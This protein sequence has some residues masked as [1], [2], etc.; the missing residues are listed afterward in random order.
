MHSRYRLLLLTA[1]MFGER[2]NG[3]KMNNF[4]KGMGVATVTPF[5]DDG[6]V[7][8]PALQ[9]LVEHLVNGGVDYLVV[10]GTTAETPTLTKEERV[11]ILDFIKEINKGR[12]T[13]VLGMGGN[14]TAQ[15]VNEVESADLNGVDA[16]LS[17]SPSYNK[18]T[19][20]GIYQHYMAL[21]KASPLPVILYNVPGRTASNITADTTLRLAEDAG[22]II[23]IK[24][25]SNDLGQITRIIKNRPSG[26]LV[27]SGDD[28]LTLPI[29]SLGGDGVISVV[30]NAFPKRFSQLV[31]DAMSGD[32]KAARSKHYELIDVIE[33]LFTEG[34]PGGVKA[35]L[36]I[37]GITGDRLRLPLVGISEDLYTRSFAE[38]QSLSKK[39]HPVSLI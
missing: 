12:L 15:L 3:Q 33:M 21:S 29:L 19:Q 16:I 22:N 6:T 24:E 11:A 7:D 4:I 28:A 25:A 31:K 26:F 30:G 5:S 8:Y 37:L 9:R 13:I 20:E 14:N 2:E 27:I 17:A 32:M 1:I 38:V 36:K 39:A 23:G 34:N 18:P 35:V 10:Q